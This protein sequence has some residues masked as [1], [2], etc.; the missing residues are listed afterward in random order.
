MRFILR[1][2]VDAD[3]AG[4]ALKLDAT[5]PV[6]DVYLKDGEE[7]KRPDQLKDAVGFLHPEEPT[8]GFSE[9][10]QLRRKK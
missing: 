4:E 5:T 2:Y 6:H 8:F 9:E 3:C 10:L 1:K 7:P